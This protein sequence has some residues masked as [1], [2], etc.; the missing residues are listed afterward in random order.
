MAINGYTRQYTGMH[1]NTLLF[2]FILVYTLQY[3]AINVYTRLHKEKYQSALL[4]Y[5]CGTL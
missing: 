3:M 4:L 1:G 2:T 5:N